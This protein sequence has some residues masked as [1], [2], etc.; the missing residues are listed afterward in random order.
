M[1]NIKVS[2]IKVNDI[3]IT[4]TQ[5]FEDTES[6]INDLEDN[7]LVGML[8]GLAPVVAVDLTCPEV[9]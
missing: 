4:G 1:A 2:D 7:E 9:C 5:L 8:G 6:F 3:K